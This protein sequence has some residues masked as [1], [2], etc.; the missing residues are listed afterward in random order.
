MTTCGWCGTNSLNWTSQCHACGGRMP[1][2]AGME[3]GEPPPT[4]PRSLPRG[5]EFRQK[6][7]HNV[8]ALVGGIF[9]LIGTLLF[10]VFIFVLPVGAL[11]PFLFMIG[12]AFMMRI[13]RKKANGVLNAFRHGVAV[14]GSVSSVHLDTSQTINGRHP[15]VLTYLF[16]VGSEMVEGSI[17]SFSS[18]IE[19]RAKGQP[20][21]VLYLQDDPAHS[22]VYPPIR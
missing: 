20:L 21:W 6:W 11:L 4:V 10:L 14:Q 13:G 9:F 8:V 18:A 19:T 5:F 2:P 15:W 17:T 12:G 7:S 3:L 16:P 1:V 22:T